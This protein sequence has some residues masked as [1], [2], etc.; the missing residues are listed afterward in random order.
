VNPRV[1][2]VLDTITLA[3]IHERVHTFYDELSLFMYVGKFVVNVFPVFFHGQERE[4]EGDKTHFYF[5]VI[6]LTF[7]RNLPGMFIHK[8]ELHKFLNRLGRPA[9]GPGRWS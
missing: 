6:G 5:Q 9:A 4:S 8:L 3:R 1:T 2:I 7:A